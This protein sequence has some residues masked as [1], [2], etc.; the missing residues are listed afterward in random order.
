MSNGFRKVVKRKIPLELHDH[1]ALALAQLCKRLTWADFDRMS[2]GTLEHNA[3]DAAIMTLR[4][5]L[6]QSGFNPR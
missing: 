2:V 3:M 1:E 4:D 5:A 6:A